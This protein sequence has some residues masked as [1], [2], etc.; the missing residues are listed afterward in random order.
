[1]GLVRL[2][3]GGFHD[4]VANVGL[5]AYQG[6]FLC[7]F[8]FHVCRFTGLRLVNAFFNYCERMSKI[9]SIS[10]MVA[11]EFLFRPNCLRRFVRAGRS[12]VHGLRLGFKEIGLVSFVLENR[13]RSCPF[14]SSKDHLSIVHPRGLF[15]VVVTRHLLG[16]TRASTRVLRLLAVVLRTPLRQDDPASVGLVGAKGLY[17]LH[18]SIFLYVLLSRSEDEQY[19]RDG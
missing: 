13:Y 10:T 17:R 12:S 16:V 8:R 2:F 9:W 11:L 4:I 19:V 6:C 14:F 3:V 7:L 18:L 5:V 1:M 15:L